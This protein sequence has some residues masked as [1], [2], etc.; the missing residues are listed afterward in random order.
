MNDSV[1]IP[2]PNLYR[3]SPLAVAHEAVGQQ[4]EYV[5]S[6]VSDSSPD[7]DTQALNKPHAK[8]GAYANDEGSKDNILAADDDKIDEPRKVRTL[9]AR[10]NPAKFWMFEMAAIV[11]NM[12]V[13]M[14]TILVLSRYDKLEQPQWLLGINLGS[15]LS[16]SSIISRTLSIYVVASSE[17]LEFSFGNAY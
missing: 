15:L 8:S 16:I 3:R 14:A 17:S 5:D 4:D 11:A 12:V 1:Y 9:T 10:A 6:D 7:Q 2:R 13:L